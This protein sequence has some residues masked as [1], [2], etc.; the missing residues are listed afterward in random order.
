MRDGRDVRVRSAPVP[1]SGH[2]LIV[3]IK[4]PLFS[5]DS[6]EGV[7]IAFLGAGDLPAELVVLLDH[8][9]L[10]RSTDR[11]V[12]IPNSVAQI[13]TSCLP[14]NHHRIGREHL[15]DFSRNHHWCL[16][17]APNAHMRE[18]TGEAIIN[19][20]FEDGIL[21]V[22]PDALIEICGEDTRVRVMSQDLISHSLSSSTCRGSSVG[23]K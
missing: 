8:F 10:W 23:C 13:R 15:G 1:L 12:E 17:I 3:A 6:V 2:D 20:I 21:N 16:W 14:L 11:S 7:R 9:V 19:R 18:S 22:K 5:V 4:E